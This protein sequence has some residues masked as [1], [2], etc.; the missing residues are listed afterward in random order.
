[1][2][3]QDYLVI[4]CAN[5]FGR[6]RRIFHQHHQDLS[7]Y[8]SIPKLVLEHDVSSGLPY[9]SK[10]YIPSLW[11]HQIKYSLPLHLFNIS[12]SGLPSQRCISP[13]F[14]HQYA[15]NLSALN[16]PSSC[17]PPRMLSLAEHSLLHK[18]YEALKICSHSLKPLLIIEDD[19]YLHPYCRLD[20][21]IQH[22]ENSNVTA[23]FT[24]LVATAWHKSDS[25]TPYFKRF[26]IS[27]TNTTCAYVLSPEYAR[28]LL[29]A[30]F[31]YSLPI[32]FHY[33]HL[34]FKL[35]LPGFTVVNDFFVNGSC[36]GLIPSTIQ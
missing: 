17:F 14:I 3:L 8:F 6:H 11:E 26:G 29:E 12:A 4:T 16:H 21:L 2:H 7:S 22:I 15:T 23:G 1:M 32:D 19:A 13:N 31:P 10:D 18:H 33:Q 30:F 36:S 25:S 9:A 20:L 27:R 35:G 5:F 28:I 34:F 24:N